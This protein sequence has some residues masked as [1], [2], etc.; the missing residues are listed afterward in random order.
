MTRVAKL[1]KAIQEDDE[2]NFMAPIEMRLAL[3]ARIYVFPSQLVRHYPASGGIDLSSADSGYDRESG[4]RSAHESVESFSESPGLADLCRGAKGR[5]VSAYPWIVG[6]AEW[7]GS[8]QSCRHCHG[9][10]VA[11]FLAKQ[12]R[13]QASSRCK[14]LMGGGWIAEGDAFCRPGLGTEEMARA[15]DGGGDMPGAD[16]RMAEAGGERA[17]RFTKEC[18]SPFTGPVPFNS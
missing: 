7:L 5:L 16:G 12:L 15:L 9:E 18:L 17:P 2:L 13:S 10:G 14:E 8:E 3:Q 11:R 1:R 6:S 4:I